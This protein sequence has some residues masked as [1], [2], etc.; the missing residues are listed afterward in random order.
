[1]VVGLDEVGVVVC[2]VAVGVAHGVGD[3][4]RVIVEALPREGV[5]ERVLLDEPNLTCYAT[6][7]RQVDGSISQ[8]LGGGG[9]DDVRQGTVSLIDMCVHCPLRGHYLCAI[10]QAREGLGNESH[11]PIHLWV[12]EGNG[13]LAVVGV[14]A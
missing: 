7:T 1:L 6:E 14:A 9:D 10:A 11:G 2:E 13:N 12:E 3:G 8:L 5:G 4:T